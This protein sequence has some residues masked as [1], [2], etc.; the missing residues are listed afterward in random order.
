MEVWL[1]PL[2]CSWLL[3]KSTQMTP[4]GYWI[5][6][7]VRIPPIRWPLVASFALS[8]DSSRRRHSTF[9]C[10][11]AELLTQPDYT[12]CSWPISADL[13]LSL[14]VCRV[15]LSV[16]EWLPIVLFLFLAYL[17]DWLMFSMAEPAVSYPLGRA[18]LQLAHVVSFIFSL[19]SLF[20]VPI[21][22]VPP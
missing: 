9:T 12:G 2:L 10:C 16:S 18:P 5:L 4:Q 19:I 20:P 21:G 3:S 11:I 14:S 1:A 8:P 15:L 7:T 17:S 13:S 6:Y 22:P